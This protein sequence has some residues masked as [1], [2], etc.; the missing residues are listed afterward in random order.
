VK[1]YVGVGVTVQAKIRR[2]LDA[3]ENERLSG[4]DAVNVIPEARPH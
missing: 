3:A 2:D 4:A 1:E